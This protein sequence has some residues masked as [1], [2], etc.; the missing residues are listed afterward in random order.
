[1]GLEA[2]R[3]WVCGALRSMV[4]LLLL[5]LA[6]ALH[7]LEPAAEVCD[8][9]HVC[10]AA[11]ARVCSSGS[12]QWAETEE[13]GQHSPWQVGAQRGGQAQETRTRPPNKLPRL[14]LWLSRAAPATQPSQMKPL[15]VPP[16]SSFTVPIPRGGG[17]CR[18]AGRVGWQVQQ[19]EQGGFAASQ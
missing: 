12:I 13:A 6:L 7:I 9:L 3:V 5:P 18:N 16:P 19:S 2:G 4:C 10:R 14:P 8:V 11:L 17:T 1:M 15:T